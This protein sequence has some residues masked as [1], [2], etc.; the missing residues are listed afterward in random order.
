MS[1]RNCKFCGKL[2][3]TK[4]KLDNHIRQ[5]HIHKVL[6]GEAETVVEKTQ[7]GFCCPNNDKNHSSNSDTK[8][9]LEI[10][11]PPKKLKLSY[12]DTV[13][14]SCNALF[15][16][17]ETKQDRLMIAKLRR[18]TPLCYH[19]NDAT[20]S[21]LSSSTTATDLLKDN[22]KLQIGSWSQSIPDPLSTS[23]CSSSTTM[24]S[25]ELVIDYVKRNRYSST[26]VKWTKVNV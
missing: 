5:E 14:A 1:N 9:H 12:N 26:I 16:D 2:F 20:Y 22:N 6:V 23:S 24:I 18:W 3:E 13:L 15:D 21:L 25:D 7:H 19:T 11:P 10:S 4:G 8:S 17:E